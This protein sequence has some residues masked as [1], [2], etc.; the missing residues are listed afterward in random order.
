M[1]PL[2]RFIRFLAVSVFKLTLSLAT[3]L[4]GFVLLPLLRTTMH[5]LRHLVF[6]SFLAAV[7]GPGMFIDRLA[8]EWT[9]QVLDLGIP[10]NDIDQIYILC[11]FLAGGMIV[12]GWLIS[13]TF[14]VAVL[15][16]VFGILL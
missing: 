3:A 7:N 2:T 4:T 16:V 11:R 5:L 12:L 14:T 1:N 13:A 9:W 8:T 6:T 15:R 10:R